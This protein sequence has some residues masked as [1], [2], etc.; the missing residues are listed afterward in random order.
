MD[1]RSFFG[2]I[3]ALPLLA[4]PAKAAPKGARLMY[5]DVVLVHVDGWKL[6]RTS[7]TENAFSDHI[8]VHAVYDKIR[9]PIR[10]RSQRRKQLQ[11]QIPVCPTR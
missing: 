9:S 8:E 3:A 10:D 11:V 6:T 4:I 1:R 5:G 7:I 2:A